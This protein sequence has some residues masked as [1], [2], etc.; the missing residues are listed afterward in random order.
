MNTT[1]IAEL[2][3]SSKNSQG[4]ICFNTMKKNPE[5][6]FTNKG[7][8]EKYN[9]LT[10]EEKSVFQNEEIFFKYLILIGYKTKENVVQNISNKCVVCSN[11]TPF[12]NITQGYKNTCSRKCQDQKNKITKER[13][14]GDPN[15]NNIEK[16]KKTMGLKT[17]K[18]KEASKEKAKKTNL[19]KYG[20]EYNSRGKEY[21]D[22]VKETWS[23]KSDKDLKEIKEKHTNTF[24]KR[25]DVEWVSQ[26]EKIKESKKKTNLEKYGIEYYFQTK[27][28]KEKAKKTNLEKYGVGHIFQSEEVKEKIKK[29]NLER[30]GVDNPLKNPEILKKIENTNLEKYG[31]EKPLKSPSCREKMAQTNLE[32]YG[33]RCFKQSH[34]KHF[35]DLN[36]SFVSKN[37]IKNSRFLM[38]DF[39][40]YFN[41][42]GSNTGYIYK[43]KF[44]ILVPNKHNAESAI[45]NKFLDELESAFDISLLRQY[46]IPNT[47]YK[48]DGYDPKTNTVYEFLGDY[49]HG[50]PEL[51]DFEDI[52]QN[53]H[54]TFGELYIL[55]FERLNN[56]KDLGYNVEYIWESDFSQKGLEK[57][58]NL[59]DLSDKT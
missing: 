22:K 54:K 45:E 20:V 10:E 31:V 16:Q 8:S 47:K 58:K 57:V 36:E 29:T 13:K 28:F 32:R 38:S 6:F 30:Y 41:I 56:L 21:K 50:N 43:E 18:E 34:L 4:K 49:W 39:T 12:I 24:K 35:D 52:N 42:Q 48:V 5:R 37:F 59:R 53:V 46:Q 33:T 9:S 26:A 27:E 3:I 40:E 1:T 25:Y 23:K 17:D 2:I 55:T 11:E 19:E 14:Y 44:D 15:Y 7:L 51:F